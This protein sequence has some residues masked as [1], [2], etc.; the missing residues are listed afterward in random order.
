LILLG[1]FFKKEKYAYAMQQLGK[2][3]TLYF[4]NDKLKEKL[5]VAISNKRYPG[6]IAS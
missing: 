2:F 5:P 3:V 4:D 6:A 1:F